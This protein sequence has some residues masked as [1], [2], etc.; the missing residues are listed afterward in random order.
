MTK[1][2]RLVSRLLQTGAEQV[3]RRASGATA[4]RLPT[5]LRGDYVLWLGRNGGL[6]FGNEQRPTS[7]AMREGELFKQLDLWLR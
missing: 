6:R 1:H 4:W 7:I 2:D 3:I 5:S